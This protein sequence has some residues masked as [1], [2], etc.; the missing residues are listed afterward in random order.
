MDYSH[1]GGGLVRMLERLKAEGTATK[2]PEADAFLR[3][4]GNAALIGLLLDQRMLAE[5]AFIGPLKL[6]R[7]LGHLEMDRIAKMD[8]DDFKAV[9]G[10]KPAV[11]RFT[12]SM[13]ARVQTLAR[14][15]ADE[16]G[17]NAENLWGDGVGLDEIQRR[18]RRLPGF[19]PTK[20]KKVGLVLHYFGHRDFQD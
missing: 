4:D 14:I 17:G 3:A 1:L 9:F 6:K 15:L 8:P 11:H 5:S 18:V 12:N 16:Y 10:E 2:D 7:R 19:G 13:A 20:A